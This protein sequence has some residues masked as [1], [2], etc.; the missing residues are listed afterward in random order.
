MNPEAWVGLVSV[1]AVV[2]LAVFGGTLWTRGAISSVAQDVA[3]VRSRVDAMAKQL[4]NGLPRCVAHGERLGHVE[5]QVGRTRDN[6]HE[7]RN[8]V[9]DHI[10]EH[11][12]AQTAKA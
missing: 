3:V 9:T 6:V 5:E 10:A 4:D 8:L 12:T 1:G 7:L 11:L 2:L